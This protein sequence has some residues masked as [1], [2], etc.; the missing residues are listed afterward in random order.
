MFRGVPGFGARS[1]RA[2]CL[3]SMCN[4]VI[5]ARMCPPYTVTSSS[6]PS[7]PFGWGLLWPCLQAETR[8]LRALQASGRRA[9]GLA[10]AAR[11]PVF[12]RGLCARPTMIADVEGNPFDVM[13]GPCQQIL[14]AK[15]QKKS[16][17]TPSVVLSEQRGEALGEDSPLCRLVSF[18]PSPRPPFPQRSRRFRS[19]AAPAAPLLLAVASPPSPPPPGPPPPWPSVFSRLTSVV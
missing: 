11:R 1:S 6:R 18:R 9:A 4:D 7:Q 14:P 13:K 15:K 10:A 8:G 2:A 5:V 17:A 16:R 19:F 3:G 12:Y